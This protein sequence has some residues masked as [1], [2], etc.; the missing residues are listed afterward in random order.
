MSDSVP[1]FSLS[2]ARGVPGETGTPA[3]SHDT[4]PNTTFTAFRL[5][6]LPAVAWKNG[7]GTTREIACW[8]AGADMDTFDWRISVARIDRDGPFSSFDGIDRV[9]TLL[10]GAGVRLGGVDHTLSQP[11]VPYLFD[12]AAPVYGELIDGTCEDLNIMSRRAHINAEVRVLNAATRV[13]NAPA[14]MLL[15]VDAAWQVE[16]TGGM[17][18]RLAPGEGIWWHASFGE[19]TVA[20]AVRAMPAQQTTDTTAAQASSLVTVAFHDTRAVARSGDE[21]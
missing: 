6:D 14:G 1:D 10:D 2:A 4:S 9:I 3:G 13:A 16:G 17:S 5:A 18:L 21:A 7:G 11:L 20:P 12:G 15:A 19:C 8:P